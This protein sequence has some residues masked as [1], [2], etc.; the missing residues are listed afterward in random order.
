MGY[1]KVEMRK[2]VLGLESVIAWANPG[3][4]TKD[5]YKYN[6]NRDNCNGYGRGSGSGWRRGIYIDFSGDVDAVNRRL[7][8]EMQEEEKPR[9]SRERKNEDGTSFNSWGVF[10][11]IGVSG[12]RKTMQ[13]R[14]MDII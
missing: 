13:D 6:K 9:E 7:W 10:F 3:T 14:D 12:G 2:I 5:T 11:H 8:E 1:M 4:W